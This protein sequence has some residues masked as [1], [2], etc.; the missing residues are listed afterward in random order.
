MLVNIDSRNNHRTNAVVACLARAKCFGWSA[1]YVM[2]LWRAMRALS[3]NVSVRLAV[4]G[5][6][7][8][9]L[10]GWPRQALARLSQNISESG[11][12]VVTNL[13]FS[14]C[15][16]GFS[17]FGWKSFLLHHFQS[18]LASFSIN[19]NQL[20]PTRGVIATSPAS[21]LASQVASQ[22]AS[23]PVS[24]PAKDVESQPSNHTGGKSPT[25]T[26]SRPAKHKSNRIVY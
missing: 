10:P 21:Q 14:Q 6:F 23:K 16:D 3:V 19:S 12:T 24:Q 18:V 22:S 2:W 26:T 7:A 8:Q 13:E 17:M 4:S 20:H 25:R 5:W 9:A 1:H 15:F 11:G